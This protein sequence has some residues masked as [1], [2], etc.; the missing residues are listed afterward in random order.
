MAGLGSLR[1]A[2]ANRSLG[3]VLQEII[4][5]SFVSAIGRGGD[6]LLGQHG[7]LR[8][9]SLMAF[10]KHSTVARLKSLQISFGIVESDG[11]RYFVAGRILT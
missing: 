10:C 6:A 4:N 5:K 1:P 3:V 2:S 11:F 8:C 7:Y 9:S